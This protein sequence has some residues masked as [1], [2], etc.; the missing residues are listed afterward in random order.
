MFG[1]DQTAVGGLK[2]RD[3]CASRKHAQTA[4]A[5]RAK[6]Q[7]QEE[8]NVGGMVGLLW[9]E[10]REWRAEWEAM[11]LE[12][13]EEVRIM[14]SGFYSKGCGEPLMN[15]RGGACVKQEWTWEEEAHSH[16]QSE[17]SPRTREAEGDGNGSEKYQQDQ[18]HAL[19][20]RLSGEARENNHILA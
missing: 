3:A 5:A 6:A 20:F 10:S 2:K 11:R 7:K 19:W 15:P 18:T 14:Q 13:R 17:N 9:L 1:Q 16:G 4:E 12:K 8:D